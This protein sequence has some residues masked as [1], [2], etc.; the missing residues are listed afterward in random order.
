MANGASRIRSVLFHAL[1]HR[2]H[3]DI[4]IVGEGRDI[5]RRGRGRRAQKLFQ[6]PFTADRRRRPV[7][8]GGHRQNARLSE[9]PMP[10]VV[11]QCDAAKFR[12]VNTFDSVMLRQALVYKGVVRI[13]NIDD[14][15]IFTDHAFDQKFRFALQGVSKILVEIREGDRIGLHP[16]NIAQEQPLA[17]EIGNQRLRLWIGEHPAGLLLQDGRIA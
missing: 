12:T 15:A 14:A 13:Q 1:A 16:G 10:R 4:F 3:A 2:K 6:N 9:Q 17:G 11:F 8:I 5:G 7:G